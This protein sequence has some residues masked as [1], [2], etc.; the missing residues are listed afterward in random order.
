MTRKPKNSD[1]AARALT[2]LSVYTAE[3]F[4]NNNPEQ[5]QRTDLQC[6][7]CDIIAD[8]LHLANQHALNVYDVVRLACDHFEA[9]LAEEA[10]P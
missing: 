9:E 3:M 1:R 5:M 6:A 10:Q 4:D 7:L 8:L 2:A